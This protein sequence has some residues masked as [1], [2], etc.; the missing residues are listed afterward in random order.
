MADFSIIQKIKVLF[1]TVVS[2]PFFIFYFLFGL[3]VLYLII[4]DIKKNKKISRIAYIISLAF[5][6]SFFLISYF[7]TVVQVIDSFVEIIIKA[8]YFPNLGIYITML[9]II[10]ITCVALMISKK[11]IK[12]KKIVSIIATLLVD[13]FFIM[14]IA[15]ISKNK[16]DVTSE[17]KLYSDSTILTLLQLSMAL[18]TSLYLLIGLSNMYIK[19]KKYDKKSN[20]DNDFAY[21]NMGVYF[22][23]NVG[24]LSNSNTKLVKILD[25]TKKDDNYE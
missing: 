20:I 23:D 16:I 12:F 15:L 8:L 19:F 21:P 24:T 2:T 14:I 22:N 10:N 7:S 1:S 11:S 9:L 17:I 3:C 13:L 5:L 18:F 25:F 4:F 6:F